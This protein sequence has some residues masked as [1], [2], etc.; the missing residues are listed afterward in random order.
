M[1]IDQMIAAVHTK[2]DACSICSWPV[3]AANASS[4]D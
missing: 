3:E 1:C 2:S 4:G